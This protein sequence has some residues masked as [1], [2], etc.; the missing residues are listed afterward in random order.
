MEKED[1]KC[2]KVPGIY[3]DLKI[4]E[5]ISGYL[6]FISKNRGVGVVV[7]IVGNW[8]HIEL[9]GGMVQSETREYTQKVA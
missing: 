6:I 1:K 9:G 7:G 8:W 4:V 5:G 2:V 3:T